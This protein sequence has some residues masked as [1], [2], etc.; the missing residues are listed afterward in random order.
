MKKRKYSQRARAEKTGET[1]QQIAAAAAKLHEDVGPANTTI[2][3]IA[4]LAGVQRLTVY[5][6]FPDEE[7]LFEACSAHWLTK[8]PLPVAVEYQGDCMEQAQKTLQA[9]YDYY[10]G[11]RDMWHSLYR[12]LG[13]VKALDKPMR[14]VEGYLDSVRDT[15]ISSWKVKTAAKKRLSLT[16]RHCLR[17]ST[18]KSLTDTG[19][20]N[21]QIVNLAVRWLDGVSS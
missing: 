14:Q 3:A 17:Y 6:H 5:R 20:S 16:L 19:L 4:D 2:K 10:L 8:H 11:T 15:L 9:F 21:R 18:W 1:R 12:D 13:E 7:S